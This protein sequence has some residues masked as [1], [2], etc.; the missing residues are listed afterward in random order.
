MKSLRTESPP[1][2]SSPP[3][4]SPAGVEQRA[5]RRRAAPPDELPHNTLIQS[6]HLA[7]H[8]AETLIDRPISVA[9][10]AF[11]TDRLRS[12]HAL[13]ARLKPLIPRLA[14]AHSAE[15][16]QLVHFLSET[17]LEPSGQHINDLGRFIRDRLSLYTSLMRA[18][19]EARELLSDPFRGRKPTH[20][21]AMVGPGIGIGDEIKVIHFLLSF[22]RCLGIP[23]SNFETYSFC[24]EVWAMLAPEL[25]V[26]GLAASP[27]RA[28][29]RLRELRAQFP[30]SRV[31]SLFACFMWQ[32]SLS[33]LT[34]LRG[35]YEGLELSVA[36][37][38]I[39]ARRGG[40]PYEYR[41]C[42]LDPLAPNFS[43]ALAK[44]AQHLF[45][46]ASLSKTTL[47]TSFSA[48]TRETVR[49]VLNPFTSKHSPLTP[50]DW[51]Q[52]LHCVRRALPPGKRLICK[53]VTGLTAAC[54]EYAM[55]VRR[56]GLSESGDDCIVRLIDDEGPRFSRENA[57]QQVH[58]ALSRADLLLT[59]DTYT[60]HM[61]ARMRLVSIALCLNRNVKFWDPAPHTFWL[62]IGEGY[63]TI[64]TM[65]S[66]VAR[67]FTREDEQGG[68]FER[69]IPA[70]RELAALGHPSALRDRGGR[71][72][73]LSTAAWRERADAA[74]EALP[75]PLARA[76][77][78]LDANYSWPEVRRLLAAPEERLY[79]AAPDFIA[80]SSFFRLASLGAATARTRGPIR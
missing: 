27:L 37:C 64:A 11:V 47:T 50:S 6:A 41:H 66:A 20:V 57:I 63:R 3:A 15:G 8:I 17:L 39:R 48:R 61:A 74:W 43:R 29:D 45:P 44:L 67:L 58:D 42:A 30:S 80:D 52:F 26:E 7:R 28:F 59:I 14:P 32:N 49:L 12:L 34:P 16:E 23:A 24:P 75:M 78:A 73:A 25:K 51:S 77:N 53:I 60:A 21:L 54:R 10:T 36:A 13:R 38:E 68:L 22:Y 46:Q 33:C 69:F 79:Q 18:P 1:L 2:F 31:L 19:V 56:L 70:S 62:N 9:N 71:L 65:I 76:L 55:E 72:D 40:E 4:R 5:M 35:S